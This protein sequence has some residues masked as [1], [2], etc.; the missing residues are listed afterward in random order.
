[1]VLR[2]VRRSEEAAPE[3]APSLIQSEDR[4]TGQVRVALAEQAETAGKTPVADLN[5]RDCA[6]AC[7]PRDARLLGLLPRRLCR[8]LAVDSGGISLSCRSAS[9]GGGHSTDPI[10]HEKA[11]FTAPQIRELFPD[12]LEFIARSMRGRQAAIFRFRSK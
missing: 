3:N 9:A 2:A 1:M 11:Q 10:R 12:S 6:V 4:I 7:G 8:G 5:R